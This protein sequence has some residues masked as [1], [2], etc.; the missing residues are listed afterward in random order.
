MLVTVHPANHDSV[1][2]EEVFKSMRYKFQGL[3]RLLADGFIPMPKRWIVEC[4]F[5]W[6]ETLGFTIDYE[7][8]AD[9]HEAMLQ[10]VAIKLFLNKI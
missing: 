1:G 3:K 5:F 6:L 2:A 9:T 7:Y 10:I 8:R 4:T